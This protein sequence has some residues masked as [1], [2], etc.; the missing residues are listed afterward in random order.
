MDD[1]PLLLPAHP[2]RG[3]LTTQHRRVRSGDA[4]AARV[5]RL[6][7]VARYAQDIAY[8]DVHDA[9]EDGDHEAW[10]L[11]R[12]VIVTHR[13]PVFH[14]PVE[15]STWCSG[16]GPRWCAR[17]TTI[18]SGAGARV[19]VEGFWVNVDP[20]TG[21]PA[22]LS[23]H[24]VGIFAVSAAPEPLRWRR[25]LPARPRG[26]APTGTPFPLRVTDLDWM[27]HVN[28]AAYWSALQQ[29][30]PGGLDGGSGGGT[31][32]V[33]EHAAPVLPGEALELV[34]EDGHVYF[35]V[36]GGVRAVA[37]VRSRG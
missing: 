1:E 34:V 4:D 8:D 37:R 17:R 11:R 32:A 26:D 30:L 16:I 21:R 18:G 19:E 31:E 13:L 2:G 20:T 24:M 6:D 7:G 14:E 29:V 10:V 15:I 25:L 5:L 36:D 28:N 27:G 35:T 33:L 23:P 3:R 9:A 22:A 12:T